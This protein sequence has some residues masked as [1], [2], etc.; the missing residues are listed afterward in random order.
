MWN[1]VWNFDRNFLSF[2]AH[3]ILHLEAMFVSAFMARLL[4]LSHSL[5][6]LIYWSGSAPHHCIEQSMIRALLR[7]HAL[8]H[9]CAVLICSCVSPYNSDVY[10]PFD[11]H[12][13]SSF[14]NSLTL[15]LGVLQILKHST[16]QF[17]HICR[18]SIRS[19]AMPN[20]TN[21][22]MHHMTYYV[23]QN[24]RYTTV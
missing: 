13:G 19:A 18:F 7:K 2:L 9:T 14:W 8:A 23:C 16:N 21:V 24:V 11:L 3:M 6:G 5:P 17:C 22:G 12:C 15:T 10:W 20:L 1:E 4:T